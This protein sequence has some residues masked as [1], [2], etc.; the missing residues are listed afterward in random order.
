MRTF[1][2]DLLKT[3]LPKEGNIA[4]QQ[5]RH[6][7]DIKDKILAKLKITCKIDNGFTTYFDSEGNIVNIL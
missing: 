7:Q 1:L 4:A 5:F 3:P 2:L 6:N